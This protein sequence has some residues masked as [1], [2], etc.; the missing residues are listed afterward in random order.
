MEIVGVA[1]VTREIDL[2][3]EG[4]AALDGRERAL[5]VNPAASESN[6]LDLRP[7]IALSS[8]AENGQKA[9]PTGP[10]TV[11]AD[12]LDCVTAPSARASAIA[13]VPSSTCRDLNRI[14]ALIV[15]HLQGNS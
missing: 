14:G 12:A 11:P 2:R 15:G 9:A 10:A 5:A 4:L 7:T 1:G 6:A 3:R 8:V 13:A